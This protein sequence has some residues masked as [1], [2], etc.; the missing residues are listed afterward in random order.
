[1]AKQGQPPATACGSLFVLSE[2]TS[3]CRTDSQRLQVRAGEYH[4]EKPELPGFCAAGRSL[5]RAVLIATLPSA[6]LPALRRSRPKS[7]SIAPPMRSLGDRSASSKR[8]L[9]I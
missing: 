3:E 9:F 7:G 1:M 2:C 8:Y 4:R 5:G 6:A